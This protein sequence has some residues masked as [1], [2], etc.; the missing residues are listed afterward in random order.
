MKRLGNS[1]SFSRRNKIKKI[2]LVNED[3]FK[4]KMFL[5]RLFAILRSVMKS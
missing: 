2:T 5:T 1:Q 3:V 4:P